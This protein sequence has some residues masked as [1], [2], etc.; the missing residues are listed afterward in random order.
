MTSL[1]FMTGF[2]DNYINDWLNGGGSMPDPLRQWFRSYTGN[3]R[4]LPTLDGIPEP[5]LGDLTSP[6]QARMVVLGLNPGGYL[7]DFQ[8]RTGLYAEEIRELGSYTKWAANNPYLLEKWEK[9]FGPNRYHRAR[10]KFAR[11]WLE[12]P[13]LPES[14]V[15]L[16]ELY[17]WHSTSVTGPMKPDPE[18]IRRFVWEPIDELRNVSDVFAFGKPW[19]ELIRSLQKGPTNEQELQFVETLGKGGHDYG[20]RVASRTLQ[21]YR[22]PSG[23]RIIVEWHSGSAGPPSEVETALLKNALSNTSSW[24]SMVPDSER[25]N[26]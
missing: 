9:K 11:R 2:W 10:Q 8:S 6:D 12:D 21:V 25:P 16:L 7:P 17:P 23:K 3:G 19:S 18:I 4:G 15:V 14:A 22:R 13:N 20:S 24:P 26:V 5:W 1:E